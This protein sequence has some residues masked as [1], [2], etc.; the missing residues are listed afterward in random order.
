[1]LGWFARWVSGGNCLDERAPKEKSSERE[2]VRVKVVCVLRAMHL[3][4]AAHIH[5]IRVYVC[6]FLNCV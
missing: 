1:M 4:T 5:I 3:N 2:S 6:A